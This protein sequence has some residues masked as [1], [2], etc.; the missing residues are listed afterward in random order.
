MYPYII[1]SVV[2]AIAVYLAYTQGHINGKQAGINQAIEEDLIRLNSMVCNDKET[3]MI[4]NLLI[5]TPDD[6]LRLTNA[7]MKEIEFTN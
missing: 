4:N 6:K 2:M 3:A 7:I 1:V 5:D